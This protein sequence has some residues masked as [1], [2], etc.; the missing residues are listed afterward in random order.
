MLTDPTQP[1]QDAITARLLADQDIVD[2]VVDRVFDRIPNNPTFPYVSFG[3][4]QVLPETAE[5]T[6][7]AQTFVTLHVWDRFKSSA[8][9]KNLARLIVAALHDTDLT[10]PEGQVQSLM[11]ESS[12]TLPDPDGL[13]MHAVL[14]FDI[15]TDANVA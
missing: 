1:L 9:T 3:E 6:D 12:R 4:I 2:L 11:L 13:T 5:G 7:A 8:A 15:L 10:L 14:S